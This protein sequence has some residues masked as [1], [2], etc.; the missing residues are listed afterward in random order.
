MKAVR[1]LL[2]QGHWEPAVGVTRQLFELLVNMEYLGAM[3]N[4]EEGALLFARFGLLQMLLAQQRK[5]ACQQEKGHPYDTQCSPW[6]ISTWRT[7]STCFKGS[8]RRMAQ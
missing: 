1:T 6:W 3:E 8:R 4:R 7:T 5:V 2:E